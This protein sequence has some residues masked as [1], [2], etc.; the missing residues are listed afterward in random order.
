MKLIAVA[1]VAVR[2]CTENFQKT[3]KTRAAGRVLLT[4]RIVLIVKAWWLLPC[5]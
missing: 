3:R 4:S 5:F 2:S 1:A